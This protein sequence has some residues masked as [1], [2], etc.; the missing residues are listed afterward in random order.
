MID[1]SKVLNIVLSIIIVIAITVP[2]FLLVSTVIKNDKSLKQVVGF[3]NQS[4]QQQQSQQ[5]VVQ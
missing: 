3:L 5:K 1:K 2:T 4:I